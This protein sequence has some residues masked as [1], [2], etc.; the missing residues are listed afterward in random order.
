VDELSSQHSQWDWGLHNDGDEVLL[1]DGRD[2]PVDTIVYGLGS[3]PP[4]VPHPG[5]ISY[6][7][8]LEREP[9]WL[10]TDDCSADFRDWPVPSPG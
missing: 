2:R 7:H 5:G 4:I 6:G 3:Y 1:L 8:S 9:A 10:D